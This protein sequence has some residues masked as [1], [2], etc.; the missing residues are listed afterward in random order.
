MGIRKRLAAHDARFIGFDD[1]L[2]AIAEA[3]GVTT[4]DVARVWQLEPALA[5]LSP[6]LQHHDG[7]DYSRRGE[8]AV[9]YTLRRET[10]D[11]PEHMLF[12]DGAKSDY[13]DGVPGFYR[14]EV[15]DALKAAGLPVPACIAEYVPLPPGAMP[16]TDAGLRAELEAAHAEAEKLRQQ[17]ADA[18]A[19]IAELE[20]QLQA[21]PAP[22]IA[23]RINS[24]T[25]ARIVDAVAEFPAW[26]DAQK[27]SPNL[28][29]V[30]GWQAAQQKGKGN[31]S[32]VA[33]VAHHVIAEHF[34]LKD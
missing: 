9:L 33:H 28:K 14:D 31:A 34:G 4:Y 12:T 29:A 22:S 8:D 20:A 1:L 7:G 25:L 2:K 30:L 11:W 6:V 18:G 21:A 13:S 24:P 10:S 26:R 27:Q 23:G 19:R 17:L 16:A 5:G 3:E 32:R 15:A